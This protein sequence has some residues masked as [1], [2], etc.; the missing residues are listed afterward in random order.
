[1][2]CLEFCMHLLLELEMNH[3]QFVQ[4]PMK[5]VYFQ[6]HHVVHLLFPFVDKFQIVALASVFHSFKCSFGVGS[7]WTPISLLYSASSCLILHNFFV[8]SLIFY[9]VFILLLCSFCSLYPQ[10][11]CSASR[12][13]CPSRLWMVRG[14]TWGWSQMVICSQQV[15]SSCFLHLSFARKVFVKMSSLLLLRY[16]WL[17]KL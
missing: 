11:H 9:N 10:F 16:Y 17:A 7:T 3:I 6:F 5:C 13:C 2:C 8:L 15:R 4:F 12:I 14:A 1:M